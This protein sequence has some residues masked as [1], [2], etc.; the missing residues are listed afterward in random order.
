M[1][2]ENEIPRRNEDLKEAELKYRTLFEQS[3]DGILLLDV[4]GNILDFNTN[5]HSQLGYTREEFSKLRIC[6]LDP[7]DTQDMIETKIQKILAL[8]KYDHEVKHKTKNGEIRD[9]Q[10]IAQKIVL[11]GQ[12][13]LN[14]IWRDIT[15]RKKG[16]ETL[17]KNEVKL[18]TLFSILPVGVSIIDN[19]RNITDIN[20]ALEKIVHMTYEGLLKG[21]YVGRKYL[22][23]N[24]E[25][26]PA[27]QFASTQAISQQ[28]TILDSEMGIVLEDGTTAWTSV[29][30]APLPDGGA[31]VVTT[32]ISEHKRV[33]DALRESENKFHTLFESANDALIILDMQGNI[34]DFNRIAHERLGYTR[35]E[36]QR[37]NISQL[38]EPSF[39][40]MISARLKHLKK[41]GQLV[42]ELAHMKKDGSSMPVEINARVINLREKDVIFS[43]VRDITERKRADQAL[44]ESEER[45]RLIHD[46]SPLG[47]GFLD[48]SGRIVECNDALTRILGTPKDKI[49][50]FNLKDSL[51]N[52]AMITALAKAFSGSTGVYEG[53]YTAFSSLR[54]IS[55]RVVFS[56]LHAENGTLRGILF[57]MEDIT[58]RKQTEEMLRASQNRYEA[59]VDNQAEFVIR[60][61]RGG[62]LTFVNDTICRY[63]NLKR[64]DLIGKSYHPFIYEDDRTASI[65]KVEQ[66]NI[67]NP[68]AV[69]EARIVL[70]D[71]RIRWHNWTHSAIFDKDGN[72]IEYQATG[73]DI[74]D[75]R[76]V[77][78][79]LRQS[80]QFVRSILNSVDEGFI[81]VDRDYRIITANRAYCNQVALPIDDVVGKP[82]Q[83]VSRKIGNPRREEDKECAITRVFETDMPYAAYRQYN[84]VTGNTLYVETKAF[85][86]R[87]TSGA[88]TSVIESINNITG[89]HELEEERLKTQKLEA[90]GTLAGGIAHDFNNL[91]QGVFGYISLAKMTAD[92]KEKSVAA[93]EQA[94]KALH[95]SVKLTN[96]LLT[97]SKGGKPVK[98]LIDLLPVIENA[99]KFALSGSRSDYRIV[100]DQDPWQ[101]EADDGQ[102]GQVIQNIVL[103]ADQAMPEGGR[104]EIMVKN[105]QIPDKDFP[106]S[107]RKG[108]YLQIA[109]KDSGI[110]IS[111]QYITKIFDPYFTT[112]ERGSGLGLATSYAIIN[113]HGGLIDVKSEMDRG[114][115]FTI[116]LP[117]AA[118]EDKASVSKLTAPAA[119]VRAGKVLLMDD[120]QV[121]RDVGGEILK[122]LGH[123][124]VC[125]VHGEDAIKKY[126]VA[127]ESGKPF[128][129]V[130]LDLT[131]R[132]GMG[133][134]ETLQELLLIDPEV[135][136]VVSSGYSD[137]EL[138][139]KH[140]GQGFKAFLKKP[141]KV[142]DLRGILNKLLAS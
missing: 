67:K 101:V 128:D 46:Q 119:P 33:E 141:Y 20:P 45:F 36:M 14:D 54:N 114:S 71:G 111:Q 73:R 109:I 47:V 25:P 69:V 38:N 58:G 91:L 4:K 66:L 88:V 117:A 15:D 90:I 105:I 84:D 130:I 43:V 110:G 118:G 31:V 98:K 51:T 115:I 48:I 68:S 137:D 59:I 24:G 21:Q 77:E 62:I 76:I 57:I 30:A 70:T 9:V 82:Y 3:P 138:L 126:Q 106:L 74:T 136:A 39:N 107:L 18:R 8:G 104:V 13:V 135:K 122:E 6:D 52:E 125:A 5:A 123:D 7:V 81:V 12:T 129:V 95:L 49:I 124:M 140:Q 134:A 29:S 1:N 87:N 40:P 19:S 112:K 142:E 80:E 116:Y 120:D 41:Y 56:P 23:K 108:T 42:A 94:E 53:D 102:I 100:V 113:N 11:S 139:S 93:L 72:I 133:G 89:K 97:F 83:E 79:A 65:R 2:S 64:S 103:N 55:V 86:L 78:E 85:P 50:E 132:G 16:E 131:I 99:A 60:Y 27:E 10:V 32:D 17:K 35:E 44:K 28:K 63:I 96:Q 61:L 34:I 92:R 22:D 37:M 75:S 127:M 26:I 121:I